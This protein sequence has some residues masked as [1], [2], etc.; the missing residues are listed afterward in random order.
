MS[1]TDRTNVLFFGIDSLRADHMSLYGYDRLTTPHIDQLASEGAV[2]DNLYAP[3]IPT[4]AGYASMLSGR[5]C[6]GTDV[7]ALRHEGDMADEVVTLPE[8]LREH[9]YNTTCVGFTGNPASRGFDNYLDYDGWGSEDTERMPKAEKLNEV[10]IPELERLA[11]EDE[12]FLLFLRHMDPHSPYLPP[13]PYERMFYHGDETDPDNDSLEPV[14]EFE[15]FADYFESWFPEGVTDRH[16]IDAQYDGAVAYMDAAIQNILT[17]LTELGL[18]DDTLIVLTADHGETL[19]EHECW[20]DHHGLY[21]T[22]LHVPLVLRLPE[23]VPQDVRFDDYTQTKDLTPTVLDLLD[24]DSDL[25]FDGRSL[26]PLFDG[27]QRVQEPEFYLTE[28]TWMRK[29]G[30]RTLEWKLIRALEPD[31][32]LKPEVELYNLKR[33]PDELNNVAED[34]PEIVEVLTQRMNDFIERRE[35]ETGR[36]N[37]MF[38]NLNWHGH[39]GGPF[40]S[41]EEAYETLHIGSTDEAESMQE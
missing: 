25:D 8:I 41:S 13:G 12:P 31:F 38:T 34:E 5:D 15:P 29:H 1:T 40:E 39:G 6:F 22:N 11:S 32:H 16:Y 19:Y 35:E 30:W 37:P 33:D 2:F 4:T 9:G 7:V 36:T 18:K 26:T 3:H 23:R 10:A 27:D 20:Y 17:A 24:I 14:L 28:A 21:E